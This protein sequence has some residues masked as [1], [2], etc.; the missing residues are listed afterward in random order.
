VATARGCAER[1]KYPLS[2]THTMTATCRTAER[3]IIWR[4]RLSSCVATDTEGHRSSFNG[5][6]TYQVYEHQQPA[7]QRLQRPFRTARSYPHADRLGDQVVD[8]ST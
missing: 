7:Q 3:K 8:D 2:T 5:S 4:S 1:V 6:V